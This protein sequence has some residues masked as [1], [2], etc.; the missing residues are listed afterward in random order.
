MHD[1][2]HEDDAILIDGV[3]HDPI[4]AYPQSVE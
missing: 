2:E 3:V 4:V 1:A